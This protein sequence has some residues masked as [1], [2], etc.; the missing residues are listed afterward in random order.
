MVLAGTMGGF[1]YHQ[2]DSL[3]EIFATRG[4][5][6]RAAR[7]LYTVNGLTDRFLGQSTQYRAIPTQ[8]QAEGTN[9]SL[10]SIR[11]LADG[12]VERA[13]SEERRAGE[14]GRGFA[15]VATE[16]KELAGQTAATNEISRNASEAARGTQDVS[17]NVAGVLASSSETSSAAQQ[18]LMDAAELATQSLSVKRE[19]DTFLAEIRAA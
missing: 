7:E 12:L 14:A 17:M 1:A 6:E 4:R 2:L 5:I 10:T 18:V 15:V 13:I 3:D 9:A 11:H 16:V 19:V 8:Q